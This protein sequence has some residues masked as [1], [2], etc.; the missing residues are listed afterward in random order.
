MVTHSPGNN[1]GPWNVPTPKGIQDT[2]NALVRQVPIPKLP[3]ANRDCADTQGKKRKDSQVLRTPTD[4]DPNALELSFDQAKICTQL[5][6]KLLSPKNQGRDSVPF[7]EQAAAST[8]R[9]R[10]IDIN[11]YTQERHDAPKY[12]EKETSHFE[13]PFSSEAKDP[14]DSTVVHPS[15]LTAIDSSSAI[16]ETQ[17][18]ALI[19]ELDNQLAKHSP[20]VRQLTA[21]VAPIFCL[22]LKIPL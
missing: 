12:F 3:G 17:E 19:V 6:P 18:F 22:L 21:P 2:L 20:A 16:G 14:G 13:E 9:H 7:S 5:Q 15:P 10:D 4:G 8:Q 11:G 1:E